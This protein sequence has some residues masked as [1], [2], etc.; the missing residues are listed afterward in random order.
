[1]NTAGGTALAGYSDSTGNMYPTL[2]L[3]QHNAG[4]NF[5]VGASNYW[6]ERLFRV[7]RTG[8]GFFNGGIQASGADF[9]EQMAV[10]GN[11]ASYAPGDVLVISTR[12]DRAVER[13]AEA[14]STAVIGV[15]STKP[16]LLAGAPDTDDPLAG[17]PVAMVGVVPAK[18]SAE[19]GAIQRG[20]LLVTAATPGHAMR[21]GENPPQGA[22]LGKALQPLE[23]GT[24]VI[25]IL[26]VLQ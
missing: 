1:M 7:D 18:V 9:A 3:V 22:V 11:S 12:A 5:V 16:A 21:A 20:D 8:K 4:G 10:A 23:S 6:G 25:L 17:I 13:S 26:V 2:Y 19:N 24:G 14:Y 15:Y